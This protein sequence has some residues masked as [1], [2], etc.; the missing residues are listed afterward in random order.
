[1]TYD[2]LD[3]YVAGIILE[4]AFGARI[5]RVGA[6]HVA[7]EEAAADAALAAGGSAAVQCACG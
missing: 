1:M 5:C 2:Q 6:E 7:A 3:D 4:Y